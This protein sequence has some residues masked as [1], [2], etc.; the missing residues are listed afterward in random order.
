M[1]SNVVIKISFVLGVFELI[2]CYCDAEELI[3]CLKVL[4]NFTLQFFQMTTELF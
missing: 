1:S 3:G 2:F 4:S